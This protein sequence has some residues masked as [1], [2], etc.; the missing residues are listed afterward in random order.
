MTEQF[1]DSQTDLTP[2]NNN[3]SALVEIESNR[4]I[5]EVRARIIQAKRFPR[6]ITSAYNAIMKACK[7]QSLAEQAMYAYPRGNE[8]VTGPSIRLAEA[9]AQNWGNLEFGIRELSQYG[10][11]S[12]VEAFAHDLETNTRQTKVFKVPHIRYSKKYGNKKLSDPRDIYELVANMGARRLRACILGVIPGDIVE[13]AVRQCEKTIEGGSDKPLE[14]RIRNMVVK[15][16]EISVTKEMIEGRLGHKVEVTTPTELVN[17][18]KIF[19]SIQ[20]GM[21]KREDFFDTGTY[22]DPDAEEVE[23]KIMQRQTP[24]PQKSKA[25]EDAAEANELPGQ[26]KQDFGGYMTQNEIT[27]EPMM[28][29]VLDESECKRKIKYLFERIKDNKD[30]LAG[31]GIHNRGDLC[32][33]FE[34]K[35]LTSNDMTVETYE[36]ILDLIKNAK[37]EFDD[38]ETPML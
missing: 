30:A 9:I 36:K 22:E 35:A 31:Q 24:E 28:A 38:D 23:E 20:D 1:Y 6:D 17:L 16:D 18:V 11:C 33:E 2:S 25:E 19:K 3:D 29:D 4:V 7:R 26:E 15:F 37:K 27:A 8:T 5:E 12:E 32:A 34:I 13:E 10:D 21:G 14:D